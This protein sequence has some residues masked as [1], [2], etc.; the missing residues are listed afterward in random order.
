MICVFLF[1]G[2]FTVFAPT[3]EA[4]AKLPPRVVDFLKKN[5]E[6]LQEVL[7]FHVLSG[8]TYSSQLKNELVV[9][10]L[11]PKLNVRINIY[12][13]GKVGTSFLVCHTPVV[14]SARQTVCKNSSIDLDRQPIIPAFASLPFICSL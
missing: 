10:T 5:K 1:V 3:N 2:P 12:Q 6:A 8:K 7:K 4:F 9:P 13:N 14:G 11:D